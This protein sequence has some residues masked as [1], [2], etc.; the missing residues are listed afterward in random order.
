MTENKIN[1]PYQF[2]RYIAVVEFIL[3][4]INLSLATTQPKA[5]FVKTIKQINNPSVAKNRA[6]LGK[7]KEETD[8]LLSVI[9]STFP[10]ELPAIFSL[11]EQSAMM[12]GYYYQREE[13][14]KSRT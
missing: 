12:Q 14:Y 5:Q 1:V 11:S 13:L 4:D 2:G 6:Y 10:V 3:G 7:R 8:E 9:V